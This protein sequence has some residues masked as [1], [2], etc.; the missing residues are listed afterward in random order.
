MAPLDPLRLLH[1]GDALVALGVLGRFPGERVF[2]PNRR[3][4]LA[5]DAASR[6]VSVVPGKAEQH[7]RK[8]KDAA[9]GFGLGWLSRRWQWPSFN[10]GLGGFVTK[11]RGVVGWLLVG[12]SLSCVSARFCKPG[13]D[14]NAL[15]FAR[16][17]AGSGIVWAG[18][19]NS[20]H[21]EKVCFQI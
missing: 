5:F 2:C 8:S 3:L 1:E 6:F 4:T 13:G 20:V 11:I 16:A 9:L 21:D 17:T 10:L 15:A 14:R 19:G 7:L 12:L 18:A